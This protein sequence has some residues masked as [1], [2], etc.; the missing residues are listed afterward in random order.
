MKESTNNID[1][2][3]NLVFRNKCLR[4]YIFDNVKDNLKI[5]YNYYQLPLDVMIKTKRY[6][7]LFDRIDRYIQWRSDPSI[8]DA[9]LELNN[10]DIVNL[11]KISDIIGYD[12]FMV[13]FN[14]FRHVFDKYISVEK[15]LSCSDFNIFLYLSS[16]YP[17]P[18]V[19]QPLTL[20]QYCTN[21]D[22]CKYVIEPIL[23]S[24][25]LVS[26]FSLPFFYKK[27]LEFFKYY[28]GLL[29]GRVQQHHFLSIH[30][31]CVTEL[32]SNGDG[33]EDFVR[34]YCEIIKPHANL[35]ALNSDIG[36]LNI[37]YRLKENMTI[38][39]SYKRFKIMYTESNIFSQI[40][41]NSDNISCLQYFRM[42]FGKPLIYQSKD[43]I[44]LVLEMSSDN[45]G[46][47]DHIVGN[48]MNYLIST[49]D[50][51]AIKL[52][53][54][55]SPHFGY[56]PQRFSFFNHISLPILKFLI[57]DWR[58][59]DEVFF[60]PTNFSRFNCG[61][62]SLEYL[63]IKFPNLRPSIALYFDVIISKCPPTLVG[64]LEKI[65][66]LASM[67]PKLKLT[68]DLL[69]EPRR[70]DFLQ[71]VFANPQYFVLNLGQTASHCFIFIS[72]IFK[73]QSKQLLEFAL[74]VPILRNQF[75]RH[76]A[77]Y[78]Y[79]GEY[80]HQAKKFIHFV[81]D[82]C[83]LG[84][85]HALAENS[86]YSPLTR[87]LKDKRY[88]RV[89]HYLYANG[90]QIRDICKVFSN[91]IKKGIENTN[92]GYHFDRILNSK[93]FINDQEKKISILFSMIFISLA[94]GVYPVIRD[95]LFK[96][97]IFNHGDGGGDVIEQQ[98]IEYNFSHIFIDDRVITRVNDN[99][100]TL[101]IQDQT[102]LC[103]IGF[104]HH[105]RIHVNNNNNNNK[106]SNLLDLFDL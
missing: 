63:A 76:S 91:L 15:I 66:S 103:N 17:L 105:I 89:L 36:N 70:L 64:D 83:A 14:D 53:C 101:G 65:H 84:I 40:S 39:E 6:D 77:Q 20:L 99:I 82:Q 23:D 54:K 94:N 97:S 74:S 80:P 96:K 104:I 12:I 34:E 22:I 90:F 16:V 102:F 32:L 88:N 61:I 47:N 38:S 86:S 68:I 9:Y 57:E 27:S 44:D 24:C 71:M 79:F 92:Y 85:N 93:Y 87:L 43:C 35:T 81:N 75:Q 78:P 8:S 42:A 11:T 95:Y 72:K 50:L 58:C 37:S 10:Q 100:E 60:T 45:L 69:F 7:Y 18:D 5:G 30:K 98:Q 67:A 56:P 28:L 25:N 19:I 33:S 31:S 1:I 48:S 41:P 4:S 46:L 3:Y 29:F 13:L 55:Y 52:L 62:D 106:Q 2:Y 51:E 49:S 73:S 59:I 21:V 26:S